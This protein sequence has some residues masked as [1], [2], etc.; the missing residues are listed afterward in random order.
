[1][2]PSLFDCSVCQ[3]ARRE[4]LVTHGYPSQTAHAERLIS[5]ARQPPGSVSEHNSSFAPGWRSPRNPKIPPFWSH[6]RTFGSTLKATAKFWTFNPRDI[7]TTSYHFSG[8][9]GWEKK[10][11]GRTSTG[12]E[13]GDLEPIWWPGYPM[14]PPGTLYAS[15]GLFGFG[16]VAKGSSV[17]RSALVCGC[18]GTG[19]EKGRPRKPATPEAPD[20]T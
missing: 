18:S 6:S 1:M 16:G 7:S 17:C 11:R 2:R 14:K 19:G 9:G 20:G 5:C 4:R 10:V 8:S 13:V 3:T 12:R 15:C